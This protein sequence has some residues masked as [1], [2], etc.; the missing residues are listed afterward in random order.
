V[1]ERD[2]PNPARGGLRAKKLAAEFAAEDTRLA[3]LCDEDFER[4]MS[5]LADPELAVTADDILARAAELSGKRM[6]GVEPPSGAKVKALRVQGSAPAKRVH[7]EWW[8]AAAAVIAI[9]VG[10]LRQREVAR[11]WMGEDAEAPVT[12]PGLRAKMLR[13]GAYAACA[14][15]RWRA[16]EGMLR[17]AKDLDPAGDADPRVQ[18]A[19]K[20]AIAG[21]GSEAGQGEGGA[22]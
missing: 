19:H 3:S 1:T 7:W 12:T 22:R 14:S 17:A 21:L 15:Q 11:P 10:L 2:K 20:A 5:A 13:E 16:C 4:E 9:G 6:A 8:L 18:A